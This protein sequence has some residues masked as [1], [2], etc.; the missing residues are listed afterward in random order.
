MPTA[1]SASADN[2]AMRIVGMTPFSRAGHGASW[3]KT[4]GVSGD[5]VEF[6][7][8]CH[9]ARHDRIMAGKHFVKGTGAPEFD[10]PWYQ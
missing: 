9:C 10:S 3:K 8:A 2:C 5:S 4:N 6:D 7:A 1:G